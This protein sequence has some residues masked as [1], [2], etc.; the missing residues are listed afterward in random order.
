MGAPITITNISN[1]SP[2]VATYTGSLVR[3]DDSFPPGYTLGQIVNG[4]TELSGRLFRP[5][6]ITATT[7]ELWM[8]GPTDDGRYPTATELTGQYPVDATGYGTFQGSVQAQAY[9]KVDN[10]TISEVAPLDRSIGGYPYYPELGIV[11][12][13]YQPPSNSLG[14][15]AP[16]PAQTGTRFLSTATSFWVDHSRNETGDDYSNNSKNKPRWQITYGNDGYKCRAGETIWCGVALHLP[17][18][19]DNQS[20]TRD[21]ELS[22][23]GL[24]E[25]QDDPST[26]QG[27]LWLLA[28]RRDP[29]DPIGVMSW[30]LQCVQDGASQEN[31]KLSTVT[32]DIGLWTTFV[33]KHRADPGGS[34]GE[35]TVWKSVGPYL[36]GHQR[37]MQQVYSFTG[38]VGLTPT[39]PEGYDIGLKAY[40]YA[41]HHHTG[42]G[43]EVIQWIGYD[44]FRFGTT[45]QDGTT[46][47]DVHPF[48]E[49]PP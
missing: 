16:V 33:I 24:M 36:T 11:Q 45:E 34:T 17:S 38:D 27:N 15:A 18:N 35:I 4:M 28:L 5:K 37:A 3:D 49:D 6:N 40:K 48:G 46:Y 32:E 42:T 26:A 7:F 41:W 30:Q 21:T 14:V 31:I 9:K 10:S 43:D 44:N 19:F 47:R 25:M 2:A 1:T 8:D 29:N 12:G 39:F 20:I 23:T 13:P 22:H